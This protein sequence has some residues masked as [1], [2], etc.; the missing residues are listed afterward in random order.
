MFF[1]SFAILDIFLMA[2]FAILMVIGATFDK[3]RDQAE[4]KWV[5]LI[6]G[7]VIFGMMN[8]SSWKFFGESTSQVVLWDVVRTLTFWS[9]VSLYLS[10][11]LVYSVLEFGLEILRSARVYKEEWAAHLK[12]TITYTVRDEFRNRL[13]I[14]PTKP[15]NLENVQKLTIQIGTLYTK[16]KNGLGVSGDDCGISLDEATALAKE[17]TQRFVQLALKDYSHS[18]SKIIG[19]KLNEDLIG[20]SPYVNVRE[21]SDHVG[22]W[23]VLW[24]AYAAS[25]ILGDLFDE[26]FRGIGRAIS[27]VSSWVVKITFA[28]VFKI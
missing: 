10:I 8:W 2:A 14:N 20:V 28:N 18:G 15:T 7:A 17:Q 4:P 11:G 6:L 21:L 26:V 13:P 19:I 25:L 3:R 5:F 1:A 27:S 23:T 16:V 22:A 24:P 12:H 9:N